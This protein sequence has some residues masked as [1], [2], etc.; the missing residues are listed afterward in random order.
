[1][2]G[3]RA[4]GSRTITRYSNRKLYD[5]S[6]RRYVTLPELARLVARG[7]QVVVIDRAT[8]A[9]LTNLA[10]AQAL[11]E[12]V[13]EGASRIPRQALRQLI[14]LT[15]GPAS[16]WGEWPEPDETARRARVEAERLV[17]RLLAAG[18]LSLDDAV[19]L[20]HGLS[21]VVQ[22]LMREA[23]DGIESRLRSLLERGGAVAGRSLG[24]LRGRLGAHVDPPSEA[25]PERRKSGPKR[26][27]RRSGR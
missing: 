2:P 23:Q 11:L 10:L 20:R 3:R 25:A 8:G 19:A 22:R 16:G 13:R 7:E 18:R 4:N 1:M 17:A 6:T 12:S 5:A 14:R 27:R 24:A 21:E 15:S 26:R 9:D